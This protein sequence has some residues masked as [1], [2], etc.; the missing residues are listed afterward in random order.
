MLRNFSKGRSQFS[1]LVIFDSSLTMLQYL[2]LA[3]PV[4]IASIAFI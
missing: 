1:E 3:Q 4:E 2:P